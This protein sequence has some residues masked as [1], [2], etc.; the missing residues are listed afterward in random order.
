VTAPDF[1]TPHPGRPDVDEHQHLAPTEHAD[2]ATQPGV[3]WRVGDAWQDFQPLA[4]PV[5]VVTRNLS[6]MLIDPLKGWTIRI[7]AGSRRSMFKD[8]QRRPLAILVATSCGV[9]VRGADPA[10][11]HASTR[12]RLLLR[13]L[14]ERWA[15]QLAATGAQLPA[16]EAWN[17]HTHP[18]GAC[19]AVYCIHDPEHTASRAVLRDSWP[20]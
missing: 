16:A 18:A 4:Q 3:L 7:P 19:G 9:V 17:G 6:A 11:W 20:S 8:H 15:D 14:H 2:E 12:V 13:G 10:E 1:D 5:T